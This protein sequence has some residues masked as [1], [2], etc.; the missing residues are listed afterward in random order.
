M[1]YGRLF[2]YVSDLF[3]D[4]ETQS[5]WSYTMAIGHFQQE[6]HLGGVNQDPERLWGTAT[7][8]PGIEVLTEVWKGG[9]L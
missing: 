2:V 9:S 6:M 5:L 1:L 7:I 3:L 8:A 4:P